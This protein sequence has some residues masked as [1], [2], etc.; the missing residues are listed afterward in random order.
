MSDN[1]SIRNECGVL[2]PCSAT[3]TTPVTVTSM[4]CAELE[5]H[6]GPYTITLRVGGW[7]VRIEGTTDA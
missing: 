7:R 3:A 2:I 6:E 4:P 5:G 1:W